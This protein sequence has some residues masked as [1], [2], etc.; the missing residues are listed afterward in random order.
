[1]ATTTVGEKTI[2][3]RKWLV[4]AA[5]NFTFSSPTLKVKISQAGN[6]DTGSG[7]TGTSGSGTSG[8]GTS[9]SMG[10]AKKPTPNIKC[11][12]GKQFK[13]VS[14]KTCPKGWVKKG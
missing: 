2:A 9:G 12:K 3:G 10:T 4:I 11:V 6:K 14:A 1:M 5:Y 13:Y 7:S 8:S